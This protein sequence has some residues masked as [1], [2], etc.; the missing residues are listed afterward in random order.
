MRGL[1]PLNTIIPY[2][3]F[4]KNLIANPTTM[5]EKIRNRRFELG[6]FQSDVAK[7]IGVTEC[8]IFNWE[9]NLAE[10]QIRFYSKIILFL[11]YYPF[12][13][14]TGIA[15][16]IKKYRHVHGLTQKE[17]GNHIGVDGSTI[18]SWETQETIPKDHYQKC[19]KSLF[20]FYI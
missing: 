6:L 12:P 13:K 2:N 5:G 10:P 3:S 11:G 16:E 9:N 7:I 20:S 8:S 15:F 19:L 17:F 4:R 1:F 18:C 14:N